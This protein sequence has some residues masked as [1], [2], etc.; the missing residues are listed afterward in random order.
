MSAQDLRATIMAQLVAVAP[1]LEGETIADDAHFLDDLGIDSMD[2]LN[3]VAALKK[4]LGVE[5][6]EGDFPRV[7]TLA[8]MTRYLT[9]KTA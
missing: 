1:D 5:I 2:F 3:L 4:K 6:P 7:A 8:A 9:E